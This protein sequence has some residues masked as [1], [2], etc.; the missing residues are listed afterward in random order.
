MLSFQNIILD[1]VFSLWTVSPIAKGG[2]NFTSNDIGLCL[3]VNG[4]FSLFVQL[5]MYPY[6]S[7][8]WST[9]QL[10]RT[11]VLLYPCMFIALPFISTWIASSPDFAYLT[12]PALLGVMACRYLA[13]TF[14]F[15][16]VMIMINNSALPGTLGIVNGGMRCFYS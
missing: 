13:N 7:K 12:W 6:A 8:K 2:L 9:V 5:F 4:I 10:Y 16:A 11:A 15:T 14:C 1:E 3:S